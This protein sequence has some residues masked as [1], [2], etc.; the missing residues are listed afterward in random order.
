MKAFIKTQS[1]E[2][3]FYT[4][5]KCFITELSNSD[6]DPDVSIARA[7]IEAGVTTVWHRLMGTS[8]RYVIISGKGLVEVGDLPAQ[9]LSAGDMVFIPAMCRQ[10]ITN[11]GCEDLI[12][13]A[14][15]SPRF[16]PSCYEELNQ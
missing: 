5:E 13:L 12:F 6:H 8:E 16:T 10:R 14:V 2:D 9:E 4:S 7:R 1:L 3:E 15:C 11:I